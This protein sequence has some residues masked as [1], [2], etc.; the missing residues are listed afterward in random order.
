MA[1][2]QPFGTPICTEAE[3][4][5]LTG[6][7]N[8]DFIIFNK[9]TSSYQQRIGG[10]WVE[11]GQGTFF[12]DTFDATTDWGSPSGGLYTIT[13]LASTHGKGTSVSDV[14]VYETVGG[15]SEKVIPNEIFVDNTTGDVSFNVSQSPDG[16]FAGKVVIQGANS[17]SVFGYSTVQEEGG[18]LTPRSI[19]NFIGADITA[20][21]NPGS[22]RTDVTISSSSVAYEESF[23]ATTSWGSPSGGLYTITV[24]AGTHGKGTN[25]SD[26]ILYETV[27]GDSVLVLPNTS[28]FNSSTGDTSFTVSETPDG[29]FAGKVVIL[30]KNVGAGTGYRTVQEDGSAINQ[31]AVLNFGSGLVA[32]DN[33]GSSRTDVTLA[34]VIPVPATQ[35]D[36]E[37]ANSTTTY[38]S[39]G[40]QHYHPSALKFWAKSDDGTTLTA[41]YNVA[42]VTDVGTGVHTYNFTTSFSSINYFISASAGSSNKTTAGTS[43]SAGSITLIVTDAQTGSVS[44]PFNWYVGGAGDQ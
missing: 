10:S 35:A 22:S 3:K 18:S 37:T 15:D 31:R 17:G 39:P 5:S 20:V 23:D 24:T 7:P 12:T 4:S 14:I 44:D 9:T 36:Q 21:D 19:I 32:T 41:T 29:R 28:F 1:K 33:P 25:V 2:V 11:I 27:G 43:Q 16:R 8:N 40:R 42:S 13:I 6:I 38:V 34:A 30:G 26:I